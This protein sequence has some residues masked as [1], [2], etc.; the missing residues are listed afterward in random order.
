MSCCLVTQVQGCEEFAK[1]CHTSARVVYSSN[2]LPLAT[3]VNYADL[4]NSMLCM[5]G[6]ISAGFFRCD[7]IF[8]QGKHS[9]FRHIVAK[10][11]K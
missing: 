9:G 10:C 6:H 3:C 8:V 11:I 2:A 7:V 1:G 5:R 4:N